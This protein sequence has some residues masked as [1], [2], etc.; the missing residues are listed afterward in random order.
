VVGVA[1]SLV[2]NRLGRLH[3]PDR[4][5]FSTPDREGIDNWVPST[6]LLPYL[7]YRFLSWVKF[8]LTEPTKLRENSVQNVCTTLF[9]LMPWA[10]STFI[11]DC[12]QLLTQIVLSLNAK[13]PLRQLEAGSGEVKLALKALIASWFG[14]VGK[15]F[16]SEKPNLM[17]FPQIRTHQNLIIFPTA[18]ERTLLSLRV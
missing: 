13:L 3:L 5:D 14:Q 6:S 17:G 16:K 8:A 4:S 15:Q 9:L 11:Q 1:E 7:V 2:S 12:Q 10:L 18:R